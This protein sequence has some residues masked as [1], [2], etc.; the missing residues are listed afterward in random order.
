MCGSSYDG[1][2]IPPPVVEKE[3]EVTKDTELPSTEDIQPPLVKIKTKT[4]NNQ[5]AFC[6]LKTKPS[7]PYPSR[8]AKE[9]SALGNPS[10]DTIPFVSNFLDSHSFRGAILLLESLLNNDPSPSLNQG[11]YL[12]E[13]KKKKEAYSFLGESQYT[14]CTKQ[15]RNDVSN[16]EEKIIA[17]KTCNGME[18]YRIEYRKL[19]KLQEKTIYLRR[20]WIQM[21]EETAEMSTIFSSSV[22]RVISKILMIKSGQKRP[23]TPHHKHSPAHTERLLIAACLLVYAIALGTFQ[24]CMYG[25]TLHDND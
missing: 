19:K 2:P 24:R 22:S 12:P 23:P 8:L 20:S 5:R 4:K 6:W 3:P 13:I 15:R 7:L 1:P 10:P 17:D 16:N 9:N 25:N 21:L 11:N 18:Q 14:V